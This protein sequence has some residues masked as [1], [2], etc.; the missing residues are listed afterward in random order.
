MHSPSTHLPCRILGHGDPVLF[1]HGFLESMRMWDV[2]ELEQLPFQSILIDLPG[3]GD[4]SLPN[5]SPTIS[6]MAQHVHDT[7][8]ALRVEP[9]FIVGHSMGGYVALALQ[10]Y[11]KN[12]AHIVFLNSNFWADSEQKKRDRER[13]AAAVQT[14][15]RT[16]IKEAIPALFADPRAFEKAIQTL[17]GEATQMSAEAIAWAT[18]AMRDRLDYSAS[19][20]DLPFTFIQGAKDKLIPAEISRSKTAFCPAAYFE[21]E[22]AGHMAHLEAT[23][24]VRA[25]LYHVI[26]L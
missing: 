26:K 18:L 6:C 13:V 24:D 8:S 16:F 3:H 5:E 1:L 19:M 2:L 10:Q 25:L 20:H 12:P 22:H 11:R 4:A 7:L 21:L 17:V 15:K 14:M 23:A 9:A